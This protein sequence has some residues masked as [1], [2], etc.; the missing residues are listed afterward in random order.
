[1]QATDETFYRDVVERSHERPIVVDFWAD[2]CGP[3]KALEPVLER[4]VAERPEVDL[5]KVDVDANPALAGHYAIRSIPAVKAFRN[6]QVVA[7]LT[8]AQSPQ[9][10]ASFLDGLLAPP[11]GDRLIEELRERGGYD[12][13]VSALESGDHERALSLLLERTEAAEK[14][15][16]DEI[17]GF[18]VAVFEDLG[19]E[20]PLSAAYRRRLAAILY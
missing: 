6:G 5:V 15:E 17:R 3:C 16:R 10:V 4:E 8:G 14:A 9:V 13:V 7:E 12:D 19:Q 2:W 1:V 11:A 18:M 20:H